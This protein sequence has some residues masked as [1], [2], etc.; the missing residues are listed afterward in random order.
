MNRT[1]VVCLLLTMGISC[2]TAVA[3]KPVTA[4]G[5]SFAGTWKGTMNDLPGIELTIQEHDRKIAGEVVFYFQQRANVNSPWR[6][7]PDNAIPLL[8]PQVAGNVL[9]FEIE[10][11]VCHGCKE[12]G[13][14]VTFRMELAGV[15][16]ARLTRLDEDGTEGQQVKLVRSPQV[17]APA[18]P[19]LQRGISVD[20]PATR[21]ASPMPEAEQG[22]ALIV[23]VREE[24]SLYIG[25]NPIELDALLGALQSSLSGRSGKQLFIKA[26]ARAPYATVMS[27]L[28]A[29][30]AAGSERTV[31][32]TAQHE[33]AQAGTLVPP[34]GFTVVT[35][36]SA[37]PRLSM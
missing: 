5:A 19:P 12:L 2:I 34:R 15:N 33:S 7:T 16:E 20:M 32:L 21:N 36:G 10:H 22:D 9:T 35:R 18:A 27:V 6:A 1:L 26:D 31:L 28:D 8:K 11:H 30:T 37:R 23:T 29:A 17:S 4:S 24:G 3:D 14:N 25:V 13:P